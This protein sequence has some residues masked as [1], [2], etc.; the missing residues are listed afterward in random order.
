MKSRIIVLMITGSVLLGSVLVWAENWS[1]LSGAARGLSEG[2][3]GLQQHFQ[4][5]SLQEQ[6]AALQRE[7]ELI[8]QRGA[9]QRQLEQQEADREL[10]EMR[11]EALGQRIDRPNSTAIHADE[12]VRVYQL[13]MDELG[14]EGACLDFSA[15]S[16]AWRRCESQRCV[17][18]MS[19]AWVDS[20]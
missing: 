9:L 4:Q 10:L 19:R 15:A 18:L 13:C 6:Q 12:S 7:L 17:R 20:R 2:L 11:L 8:R 3:S 1:A 16:D 5:K 14:D